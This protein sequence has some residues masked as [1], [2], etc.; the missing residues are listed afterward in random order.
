MKIDFSGKNLKGKSYHLNVKEIW[1][2]TVVSDTTVLN[3]K[4]MGVKQF[5]TLKDAVF[6]MR[7]ISKRT[8]DNTLKLTFKFPRLSVTKEYD[9]AVSKD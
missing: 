2:G 5:E 7:V 8:A 3:S 4:N 9:A 6:N 1:N